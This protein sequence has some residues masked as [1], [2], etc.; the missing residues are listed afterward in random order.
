MKKAATHR[1]TWFY[2]DSHCT[3]V[4]YGEADGLP[5][6]IVDRYG[7]V[8]VYQ[9]TTLGMALLED[10]IKELLLD[11]FHPKTLVFRHDSPVRT[12]EGLPL[13]KGIAHGELP[14]PCW[15]DLDGIEFLIDPFNGQ[16]TGFYL[17]Q[18]D[19]RKVLRRW[20]GGRECSTFSVTT[21]HGAFQRPRQEHAR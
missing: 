10:L 5:G 1:Q 12:L 7:E 15:I 19:N 16:K 18:R 11:L 6:L 2:P 4:V 17:D 21:E 8:L 14:D 3:R 20:S 13:D 9:I